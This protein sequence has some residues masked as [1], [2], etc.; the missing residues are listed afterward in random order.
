MEYLGHKKTFM[1]IFWSGLWFLLCATPISQPGL[2]QTGNGVIRGTVLDASKAIVP[3]AQVTITNQNTNIASKTQTN[4]VGIYYLGAVQPGPYTVVVELTGFKKWEG[5]IELQVGQTAVVNVELELGSPESTVEVSA[6]A[7]PITTESS[8]VADVKDSQRIRQL[9]LNGRQISNLFDLTPGVEGGGNPRVNGMKV[10]SAEM[11]IDGVSIVDRF[12]GGIARVQ[13]GLD[14]I[15]E[16]RI[17]T[18][19][20]N[21]QYSRP[22]T[23]TLLTKS[24]TNAF[25]GSLFETHRNN[26]GGL[27][28]RQRQDE[29]TSAK[30]I[31][32]EFGASAGGPVYLGGLYD[33]R[34]K[35]FWF[36]TYEGR[37]QRES[38]FAQ[39]IV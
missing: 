3:G 37:R 2:A 6:A 8:E 30:L 35:T 17:E 29:E 12:G 31:R 9:P 14:T 16:F 27:R 10:G 25:H 28:A 21:A 20:S 33:G 39:A 4:E 22:A 19:G 13:P 24:G 18:V 36:V 15:Q 5:K 38:S 1:K 26:A 11:L 23:I 34:N 7:P 32:N